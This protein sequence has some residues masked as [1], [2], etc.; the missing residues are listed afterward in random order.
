[1]PRWG[2]IFGGA[3]SGAGGLMSQLAMRQ[4]EQADA[5]ERQRETQT[6]TAGLADAARV[7][8]LQEKLATGVS[9]GEFTSEQAR[10]FADI[11]P[12]LV[13]PEPLSQQQALGAARKDIRDVP[14]LSELGG[15]GETLQYIAERSDFPTDPFG[16]PFGTWSPLYERQDD[17]QLV[18]VGE[19]PQGSIVSQMKDAL[20]E[21]RESLERAQP[22]VSIAGVD[23]KTGEKQVSRVSPF[24]EAQF[25]TDSPK[26]REIAAEQQGLIKKNQDL[27]AIAAAATPQGI[28]ARQLVLKEERQARADSYNDQ[29]QWQIN[30]SGGTTDLERAQGLTMGN[31]YW[32]QSETFF[33]LQSQWAKMQRLVKLVQDGDAGP[34]ALALISTFVKVNDPTSAITEGEAASAANTGGLADNWLNL[35]NRVR[36]GEP[37]GTGAVQGMLEAGAELYEAA[38]AKQAKINELFSKRAANINLQPN[39]VIRPIDE[40]SP[41]QVD[42][43]ISEL[44]WRFQNQ[45]VEPPGEPGA[46]AGISVPDSPLRRE[47]DP[48]AFP[49]P[50]PTTPLD[51]TPAV[52]AVETER[53][54][55]QDESIIREGLQRLISTGDVGIITEGVLR[56]LGIDPFEPPGNREP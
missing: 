33:E 44:E 4:M 54:V 11:N 39:D 32:S 38:R 21:R 1:M 42:A 40:P 35:Y 30:R 50:T 31:A 3:L 48:G 10:R 36:T 29:L 9:T 27:G 34:A 46:G 8:D 13:L 24:E 17:G 37:L 20:S 19:S 45:G 56:L 25:P 47:G 41:G 49:E 15:P 43:T 52:D 26:A 2:E 12:G 6:A 28:K 14:N 7:A 53:V 23:P 5:L 22:R 55:G 16:R 51:G 18:D